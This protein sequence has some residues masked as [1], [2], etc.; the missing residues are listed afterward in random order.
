MPD[1]AS[2]SLF[3]LTYQSSWRP[4]LSSLYK[5]QNISAVL[6]YSGTV[7]QWIEENHPEFLILLEEMTARKQV[8]LLGGG[9]FSPLLSALQPA[10]KVG[11]IEM[12]TTYLRKAF[13]K[14][15][16]GGW[17]YEYSWDENL[18]LIF[19]NAGLEY[20]FLPAKKLIEAGF[21]RHDSLVPL[22]A[23]DQRKLLYIF[24]VLDLEEEFPQP[25]PFEVALEKLLEKYPRCE[26]YTI[27]VNGQSVPWMWNVSGVES[28]DVLFEKSFAWFQKNCLYIETMTAQAYARD[29]RAE[30][31]FYLSS[32]S[33]SRL[34]QGFQQET[35]DS[36][37][38]KSKDPGRMTA[39][40]LIVQNTFSR[41]LYDK[42]YYVNALVTLLRGDKARKKS[43]QEDLWKAQ[44]GD[45]Y[46]EG[47]LGGI[48]RPEVRM[49]AY[50]ALIEA[51]KTTRVHGSFVPGIILDDIDC[52]GQK[53]LL[54]QAADFNCYVHEKGASVFELDS[55]RTKQNYC[56]VYA[57]EGNAGLLNSFAD[58]I[59]EAGSF[60]KQLINLE[61]CIF[62]MN[63][64]DK[65]IQK[66]VFSRDIS[67]FH[68][69]SLKKSYLFQ[70]HCVSVDYEIV[71]RGAGTSSFRFATKLNLQFAPELDELKF[72]FTR[73]HA[74]EE[75]PALHSQLIDSIE[76]VR[77]EC[78]QPR[79]MMELR[80]DTAFDLQVDQH[81]DP[82][83][84]QDLGRLRD[85]HMTG[86][87]VE[88]GCGE[89]FYQG[90]S[91][92]FGW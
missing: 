41:K 12:L 15:P 91:M 49:S 28:P 85:T 13:G 68:S 4:F 77:I 84:S 9:F 5:F 3:E 52:D 10:D 81:M 18:P 80:T 72:L 76:S 75:L 51:E 14:R 36:G 2:S 57:A 26:L 71:N 47:R 20:S 42:M 92:L 79:N 88:P 86:S 63:E 58:Q 34:C 45:A 23:E 1:G 61:S 67:T 50:R 8:E 69:L 24:P 11:Q 16:I 54:Y 48:R 6:Y 60:D 64:K 30:G 90:T 21:I 44:S 38:A 56:S 55:F 82:F 25:L 32:C 65:T 53:E 73:G 87:P 35:R 19:R 66:V 29:M 37:A 78:Q 40:Q 59:C 83:S 27:M 33:S 70:K 74:I 39:R 7:L 89:T 31:P 22:I 17:L 62:T 46:W 43:A